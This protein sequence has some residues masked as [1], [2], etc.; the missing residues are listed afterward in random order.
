M[1]YFTDEEKQLVRDIIDK[2]NENYLFQNQNSEV[3]STLNNSPRA[4]PGV[5]S[6]PT[7]YLLNRTT[8]TST[9]SPQINV[10]FVAVTTSGNNKN[11]NIR[12][13]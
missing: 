4:S 12:I 3:A 7:T 6:V 10:P 8:T 11:D 13:S 5:S 9:N 2:N 1:K